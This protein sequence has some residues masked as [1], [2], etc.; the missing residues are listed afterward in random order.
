MAS[1][2]QQQVPLPEAVEALVAKIRNEQHQPALGLDT[3]RLLAGVPEQVSIEVLSQI[4][5]H[6]IKK[7]FDGFIIY[8]LRQKSQSPSPTKRLCVPSSTF[9]TPTPSPP[10]PQH[11][12]ASP[13][14][15]GRMVEDRVGQS[16]PQPFVPR[17]MECQLQYPPASNGGSAAPMEVLRGLEFRQAFLILSYL[18]EERLDEKMADRIR[19]MRGWGLPTT[20]RSFEELVWNAI[21]KHCLGDDKQCRIKNVDWDPTKPH[22]YHCIVAHTHFDNRLAITFKGPYVTNMRNFLQTTMG[23]DNVL[24]VKFSDGLTRDGKT[25][26]CS[27]HCYKKLMSIASNGI[28]VGLHHFR[29]FVFKDG[30]KE[31][32]KKDPANSPV[33]CYFIRMDGY[34][35]F[36]STR[37]ARSFFM[38]LDTLPDL[39]KYMARLSLVLSKTMKLDVP[40]AAVD[41]RVEDD[42]SCRDKNNNDVQDKKGNLLIHT[43]GTGFISEDLARLC[44]NV[45]QGRCLESGFGENQE[46]NFSGSRCREPPLLM[47]LRLFHYG[48]AVKGTLLV[49][50]KIGHNTI[51]VRKSMVKVY[52]D[53]N[54]SDNPTANSLEIVNTSRRPNPAH[55]SRNLIA[56]LSSGGVPQDFFMDLLNK[57]LQDARSDGFKRRAAARAASFHYEKE[58]IVS[59]IP[60]EESYLNFRLPALMG[61]ENKRLKAGKFL[62]PDSYYLMGTADPSGALKEGEVCIILDNGQVSGKVLVYRNPGLHFGD[63]HI[64]EAVYLKEMEDYVGSSRFGIFFPTDGP[65]SLADEMA[66][67]DYDGDMFLVSKY[68]QLLESFRQSAPWEAN[69]SLTKSPSKA[70]R[71]MSDEELE[72]VLFHSFL[73]TRFQPSA[74]TG[75]AAESWLAMMDRFLTLGCGSTFEAEKRELRKN[76]LQ[77][78]DIYYDALDAPKSG[79][80]VVLPPELRVDLFPN[81]MEKGEDKSYKST[82]ILGL[83]YDEVT[84]FEDRDDVPVSEI[85]KL[86]CF[87]EEAPRELL[88][89]WKML[90]NEYRQDMQSSLQNE[91]DKNAAADEVIEKYKR[92]FYGQTRKYYLS[93]AG[94]VYTSGKKEDWPVI[95]AVDFHTTKKK[96]EHLFVEARA[97][98]QVVY[99]YAESQRR[100]ASSIK[101]QQSAIRLCGFAWRVAGTAL[102]ALCISS[103]AEKPM[104]CSESAFKEMFGRT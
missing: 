20:M 17:G 88:E 4:R 54:L 49:N 67:G 60:L 44:P 22:V 16:S 90:Y 14:P 19:E 37:E 76:I 82:S 47:Q 46:G 93:E 45:S 39:S 81:F 66:N 48:M 84:K 40:L 18:G 91:A 1:S 96:K 52:K 68:P 32:K 71:S 15:L 2:P 34:R 97:L 5:G 9:Q 51:V 3:R 53:Q 11:Q 100:K 101:E 87:A 69:S 33:K 94:D 98:Y 104:L 30:M 58:M 10:P 92:I 86:S 74:T 102:C 65:R 75:M 72:N 83:I 80:K 103:R 21:G 38:H 24:M 55:L 36:K 63:V 64:L 42:I 77:V 35:N 8:L 85:V 61:E 28:Q 26:K 57:E 56:L 13:T 7:S 31:E 99:D 27:E 43:D 23:D 89:E 95:E 79:A 29:F 78:I 62:L 50:K 6:D 73:K 12:F 59:G 41:V 25:E 70:P